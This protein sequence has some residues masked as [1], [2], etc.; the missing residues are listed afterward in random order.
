MNYIYEYMS[1]KHLSKKSSICRH[2]YRLQDYQC[3]IY[4]NAHLII[5]SLGTNVSKLVHPGHK[6]NKLFILLAIS[7]LDI[8]KEQNITKGVP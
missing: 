8:D 2:I 7:L 1:D 4:F 3:V 6:D 5:N